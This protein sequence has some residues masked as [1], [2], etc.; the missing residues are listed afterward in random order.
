MHFIT[1]VIAYHILHLL[2]DVSNTTLTFRLR[3]YEEKPSVGN[4]V[5]FNGNWGT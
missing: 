3:A 1:H 2:P 4:S 5:C